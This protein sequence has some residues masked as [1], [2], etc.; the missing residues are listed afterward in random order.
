LRQDHGAVG[1]RHLHAHTLTLDTVTLDTVTLDTVTLDTVTLDTLT[2]DPR[3]NAGQG[4][5]AGAT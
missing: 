3:P 1:Q 5:R 2:L 4:H